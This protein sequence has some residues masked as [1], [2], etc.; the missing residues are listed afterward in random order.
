MSEIT[1]YL[2]DKGIQYTTE[3]NEVVI[4]CPSCKKPK[5]Y[6]NKNS[7]LYHCFV[8]S[9]EKPESLYA[10][11]HLSQ[12]KTEW[13]DILD[14]SPSK[15]IELPKIEKDFTNK[16]ERYKHNLSKN[17]QAKKYLYK[18]GFDD[19]D[20]ERFNFGFSEHIPNGYE[21]KES[22]ISI[23]VYEDGVPKLIKYRK[24]TNNTDC[25]K[26]EREF[27][28][29]SILYNQDI[30][31]DYNDVYVV[32]GEFDCCTMI[33]HGYKNSVCGTGGEG[34][35][36]SDMY[37]KLYL[38]ES[39]TLILDAD[40]VGQNAALKVWAT[41]LGLGRC[42][43]V[44]LPDEEDVNSYFL[45]YTKDDFEELLKNKYK[46]KV[47]GISSI[48]EALYELYN[49][50]QSEQ[51][52]YELPWENLNR[53]IKGFE[54]TQLITVGGIPGFGKTSMVLQLAHHFAKKYNMPSLIT[55]LEMG[56]PKL[57]TKII[58]NHYDLDYQEVLPSEVLAYINDLED[59]P[60]YFAYSPAIT[61]KIYYNTV[62][63]ARNR[64]GCELFVFDNLQLFVRS[65]KE[66]DIGKVTKMFKDIA[67]GL[68][69]I[70]LM[71]S[72]PRKLNSER[73]PTF[74]DLKGS[75]AIAAD[76]DIILLGRRKRIKDKFGFNSFESKATVLIDKSRFSAGAR[77]QLEFVG[78]KSRFDEMKKS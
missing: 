53:A 21:E 67:M 35:L 76:S 39:I 27:G 9:A 49:L 16:V 64:Y 60:I 42:W 77:L 50:S 31:K 62:K 18:R 10:K 25:K 38:K 52:V 70:F 19:E 61:P 43:N 46:F 78:E 69:V 51:I 14:I 5:L 75:S 12:L 71:V 28:G 1:E 45:K 63:E 11:G 2:N 22:W 65:D 40:Q 15:H 74:D 57:V 17:P 54:K 33:K 68:D 20:I 8:C 44:K 7:L 36:T 23:P 32:A 4:T 34:S 3:G 73:E 30:L 66:S 29:K 56:I 6:I 72:Q 59:L 58:Q 47:E 48:T 41:R 26:Y 55:C 24:I 13:G 37:D